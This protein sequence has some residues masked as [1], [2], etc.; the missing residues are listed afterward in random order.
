MKK[1]LSLCAVLCMVLTAFGQKAYQLASP[2]GDIKVSVT[3][4]DKIYYNVAYGQETLLENGFLR[5]WCE[6]QQAGYA[7]MKREK[8]VKKGQKIQIKMARN[9]GFAAVLT[10]E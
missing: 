5:R 2:N 6:R 1:V 9:G 4:S 10:A 7:L 3:V 8:Q